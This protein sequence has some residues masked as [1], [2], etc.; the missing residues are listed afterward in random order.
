[1][2][3][4]IL[5]TYPSA[6][7]RVYAVWFS[8]LGGDS[9]RA[10]DGAG[11]TDPRVVPLWDERKVAGGWFGDHISQSPA[12]EWDA[13]FLYGPE[14]RWEG[15]PAPLVRWGRTVIGRHEE[16]RAAIAPLLSP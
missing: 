2:Q 5:D 10:W 6:A 12:T 3:R 7:V 8:M 16:F 9:R 4:E 11:L 15:E 13:Y 14:A 1:M